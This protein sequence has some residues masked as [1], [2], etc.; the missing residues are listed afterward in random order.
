M[1]SG[2]DAARV[3]PR[4]VARVL[5]VKSRTTQITVMIAPIQTTSRIFLRQYQTRRRLTTSSSLI[6]TPS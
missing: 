2:I 6:A 1:P 3:D 4:P 5:A